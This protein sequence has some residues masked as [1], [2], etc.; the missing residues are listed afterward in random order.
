MLDDNDSGPQFLEPLDG[1]ISV[2][3]EQQAGFEVV[4]VHATD[5]DL[6]ENATLV[7]SFGPGAAR[8]GVGVRQGG[9]G[10]GGVGS[11]GTKRSKGATRTQ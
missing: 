3:E 7:Y 9:V 2:R 6:G 5:A 4:Q 11:D 1:V 8:S 10:W